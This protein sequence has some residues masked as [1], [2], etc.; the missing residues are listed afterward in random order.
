MFWLRLT[1]ERPAM[2]F[3]LLSVLCCLFLT[4]LEAA[5]SE[6]VRNKQK[7][8]TEEE[9]KRLRERIKTLQANQAKNRDQLSKEQKALKRMDLAINKSS[10]S[11]RDTRSKL[12]G[13]RTRMRELQTEQGQLLSNKTTQQ[14][15]LAEQIRAAYM[16]GNQEYI[17][18]LLNQEDPG[19]LARALT[20]YEYLNKVRSEKIQ[21][22]QT[23]IAR[24]S[25]VLVEINTEQQVLTELESK[26]KQENSKLLA[27]KNEREK[28]VDRLTKQVVNNDRKL[29]EW[30]ANEA[31]LTS[32]LGALEQQIAQLIP[33][34]ALN[35]LKDLQG[36]LNWPV[37]GNLRERFG[38]KREGSQ[39]RWSGV[40]IDAVA[41][42]A[43]RAIYHGRV[44][45]SDYLRGFGLITIIDH[46]DGYMSLYGHNEALFKN[47]GDWVE[48]GERIAAVGQTGGYPREGLYFEIRYK[49]RAI[50]P[51]KFMPRG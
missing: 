17:K 1:P 48:A 32:I 37:R 41:G 6:A 12:R 11:L 3:F 15:A 14:Q 28:V 42:Q 22:L 21:L 27:L 45:Y 7:Q 18:V 43:V 31:D 33:Q 20:Y 9:L 23:T 40:L 35:G 10:N 5:D 13:S 39:L 44:V 36:K 16:G 47:T 19:K 2:K 8:Q 34:Q 4:G 29:E 50:N 30:Q 46:G 51:V 25:E 38:R 49:S 26:Q 24:L